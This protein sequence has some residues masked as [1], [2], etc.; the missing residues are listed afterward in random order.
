MSAYATALRPAFGLGHSITEIFRSIADDWATHRMYIKTK[1]E[2][3]VLSDRDLED[4]GIS[5]WMISDLAK[6]AAS[7]TRR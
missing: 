4:I 7:G 1:R 2:L 5:R 3:E 6:E